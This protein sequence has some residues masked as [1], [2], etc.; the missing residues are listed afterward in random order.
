MS[1]GRGVYVVTSL[2]TNAL[3][4]ATGACKVGILLFKQ[5]TKQGV[6]L[7]D[8]TTLDVTYVSV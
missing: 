5:R 2:G 8:A 1:H 7:H 4:K 6:R 3:G